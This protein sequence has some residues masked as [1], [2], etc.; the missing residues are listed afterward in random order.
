MKI[1]QTKISTGISP[2]EKKTEK[3][4]TSGFR[5]Y[6]SGG[7]NENKKVSCAYTSAF[8]EEKTSCGLTSPPN[9]SEFYFLGFDKGGKWINMQKQKQRYKK[10]HCK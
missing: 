4:Y 10:D 9:Y 6:D 2:I 1:K 5:G 3:T 7:E 8:G